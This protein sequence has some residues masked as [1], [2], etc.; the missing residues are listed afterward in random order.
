M[1]NAIETIIKMIPVLDEVYKKECVTSVLDGV[2]KT[3]WDSSCNKFKVA[4]MDMDG[5]STY[6]GEYSD[7]DVKLTWEEYSPNFNQN[8]K[9]KVDAIENEESAGIVLANLLGQF[10][11]QKVYPTLDAF[12]LS[13]Y[14]GKANNTKSEDLTNAKATITAL[15]TAQVALEEKE[16]DTNNCYVFI[17]PSLYNT[18]ADMDTSTSRAV[19]S[20]FAGFIKVPQSRL[21]TG[22]GFV[23]KKGYQANADSL[24]LNFVIIDKNKVLQDQKR[25][26]TKIF[27]PEENQV[28]DGYVMP[29]HRYEIADVLE[30]GKDAVYTSESTTKVISE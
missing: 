30:N 23:E 6:T 18:I 14:A 5:L 7:G 11:K 12:R 1:A 24:K 10:E 4:K 22:G 27:T 26:M 17:T 19:L 13:T 29:Y 9:L 20:D 16:I 8:T 3:E 28:S 21:F 15:R 2:M 25:L